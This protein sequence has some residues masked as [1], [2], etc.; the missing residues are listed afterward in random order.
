MKKESKTRNLL[1]PGIFFFDFFNVS[2]YIGALWENIRKFKVSGQYLHPPQ[3]NGNVNLKKMVLKLTVL[4]GCKVKKK[5]TLKYAWVL[6][7]KM[8]NNSDLAP[9]I[10]QNR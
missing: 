1:V 2:S 7:G 9:S 10:W 4:Q 6:M 8:Y 3:R 5:R